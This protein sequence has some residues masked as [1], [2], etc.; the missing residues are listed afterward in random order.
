MGMGCN[1][2]AV[3]LGCMVSGRMGRM[4]VGR[5]GVWE[6]TSVVGKVANFGSGNTVA[7]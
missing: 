4:V 5:G 1:T 3:A 6:G 2:A 7:V